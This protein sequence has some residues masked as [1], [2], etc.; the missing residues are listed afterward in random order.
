V[1]QHD[2][3]VGYVPN[4]ATATGTP[5]RGGDVK[6]GDS[7]TVRIKRRPAIAVVKTGKL[8]T[9][10]DS[11]A[12]VG[13]VIRYTIRVSNT[14][15]VTLRNVRVVEQSLAGLSAIDC[16]GGSH[17]IATLRVRHS[18]T[19]TATYTV[20]QADAEV[21]FVPNFA[22]ATGTPPHGP[23][24]ED[25]DDE[26]VPV[27]AVPELNVSKTGRLATGAAGARAGDTIHY[28]ITVRNV[29]NVTL[30]NV[31]VTEPLLS[32]VSA[33][34]C[35]GG[36]N[37]IA[38]LAVGRS[39]TCTATYVVTQA[40]VDAGFVPN[41]AIATGTPPRGPDVTDGDNHVL[42]AVA[43]RAVLAL[44]KTASPATVTRG[45]TVRFRLRVANTS[46]VAARGVR[47]CD[48]RPR[49]LAVVSA[50]GFTVRGRTLC[51]RVGT[52]APGRSRTL[53]FT[54]RVGAGAPSRVTNTAIATAGNAG[55]V[56]AAARVS[57]RGR[58][59]VTG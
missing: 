1:T 32:G 19:C 54:A 30:T 55:S 46:G 7:E 28:T 12:G 49:G 58:P 41:F 36:T 47:V 9:G 10:A 21:G 53:V 57:I 42:G 18:V 11:A 25:G 48:T 4:F 43:S 14:G 15:N 16:G 20:T 2:I 39:A 33:I 24:V 38:T 23:D 5:P 59:V 26:E 50:P 13:D 17:V 44:R 27:A 45:S 31:T 37:V 6:D 3:D 34:D 52:L 29:G 22:T 8:N 56:R 35:G 51:R 40:D